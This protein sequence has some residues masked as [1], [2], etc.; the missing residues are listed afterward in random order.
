[1]QYEF[2]DQFT[3]R[4]K[5][6]GRYAVLIRMTM[7]RATLRQYGFETY[8]EQMNLLFAVLLYIMEQSLKDES[9]TVDD[10]GAYIDDLNS[11]YFRKQMSYDDSRAMADFI[12]N[13]ILSNDG[14]AM[15]FNGYDFDRKSYEEIPIAYVNNRIIYADGGIK[16]TSYQLTD[17]G[18]DLV[19]STLEIEDNL[20]LPVHEMIFELHLKKQSYDKAVTDI[21]NVFQMLQIQFRKIQDAMVRIRRNALSYSVDEYRNI[22]NENLDTLSDTKEKFLSYRRMIHDKTREIEEA[23]IDYSDLSK[24][25]GKNLENLSIID[26][27]LGRALEE[28][29]KI[30]GSHLDLKSLYTREL[31]QMSQMSAV[32][33]F[34]FTADFYDKIL[35]DPSALDRAD[36]FLRPLFSR[37]VAKI[38]DP[39]KALAIQKTITERAVEEDEKLLSDETI[40]DERRLE[41]IRKKLFLYDKSVETIISEAM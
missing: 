34:S 22:M 6:V 40:D 4:M 28:Q 13:V 2:L 31:E 10:I 3:R 30:F 17:D 7:N 36:I 15:S 16:R 19:L 33:R 23:G 27:Y 24:E 41:Q 39:S 5:Q 14:V 18:Y 26:D 1:M 38:F 12:I 25:N 32:R 11:S 8:D 29:Q 35:T 37:E 9:C 20:K 21:R